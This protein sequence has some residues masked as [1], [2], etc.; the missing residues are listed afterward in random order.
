ML[1]IRDVFDRIRE[2]RWQ[3]ERDQRQLLSL[4]RTFIGVYIHTVLYR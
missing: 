3:D 2:P 1:Q 4:A